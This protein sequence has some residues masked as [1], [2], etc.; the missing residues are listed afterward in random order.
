MK[1]LFC[2]P[3]WWEVENGVL[4]S[5][6]RAGS[7]W[8][9]T[10]MAFS[11]PDRFFLSYAPYPFFMGYAAAYLKE[12]AGCDVSFRDSI[13]LKESYESFFGY[14]KADFFE[15]IFL[16]S[17]TSSWD[18]DKKIIA[19]IKEI[20]PDSKIVLTGQI[21]A[22][23]PDLLN[24]VPIEACIE[25]EYEKG[26]VK[27][28]NGAKG[29]VPYDFLSVGEMNAAPF[30]YY[31][32]DHVYRYWEITP[33]K[34]VYPMASVLSLRGCPYKCIFCAWP[35]VMW[36]NDPDGTGIRSVRRYSPDYLEAF[37]SELIDKYRIRH[38]YFDDDTFN[39][40]DEHVLKVCGVM[41]RLKIPWGA[42]CRLDT[43][44]MDAWRAMK[45]SG[46]YWIKVGYESGSQ[47]VI[48]NIVN[49]KLDLERAREITWELHKMGFYI[50]GTFT[51]G[52][53][54]ETAAQMAE[55]REYIKSLPLDSHQE[56]GTGELDGT[57][58]ALINESNRLKNYAGAVKD[59]N[60]SRVSD[61]GAKIREL[62]STLKEDG[63]KL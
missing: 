23:G 60:Y 38:I 17:A 35:A 63:G 20:S 50:H 21:C 54:G 40:G 3:P 14:V 34:S 43:T 25:G 27:V 16:E 52:L 18:H 19:R 8:P 15:Y 2:N 55:T 45:E 47:W 11:A 10:S 37:L 42:M 56:S 39:L 51:F 7:R 33:V 24:L 6:S 41:D 12:H 62:T 4:M 1:V 31:D 32:F 13:A 59:E 5:G 58:L 53:P 22:K 26:S 28:I 49:K 30:P 44:S 57:P 29:W 61:G 48:D 36:S 9:F 46:C